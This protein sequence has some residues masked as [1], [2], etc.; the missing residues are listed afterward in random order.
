MFELPANNITFDLRFEAFSIPDKVVIEY[1]RG[2]VVLDSGW[3]G[4]S[5]RYDPALHPGGLSG[6]GYLSSYSFAPRDE[7]YNTLVVTVFGPDPSTGWEYQIRC[8][9]EE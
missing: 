9:T 8:S 1:P 2:N 3:R 5:N 4:A 7:A 6:P